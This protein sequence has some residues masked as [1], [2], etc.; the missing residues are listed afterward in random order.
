MGRK[1]P[2]LVDTIEFTDSGFVVE[3]YLDRNELDFFAEVG[4]GKVVRAPDIEKLRAL[5]R[6]TAKGVGTLSWIPVLRIDVSS[7]PFERNALDRSDADARWTERDAHTLEVTV[8]RFWVAKKPGGKWIRSDWEPEKV[9]NPNES[10]WLDRWVLPAEDDDVARFRRA[11]PLEWPRENGAF[12]LPHVKD[13]PS[14]HCRKTV[15]H[16]PHTDELWVALTGLLDR[17]AEVG[18]RVRD[19]VT[20]AE[21][22][23]RLLGASGPLALGSAAPGENFDA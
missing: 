1:K 21:G 3:L 4:E 19:L 12:K 22:R 13:E 15:A 7:P 18:A 8:T 14:Y 16:L 5:V 17:L 10:E 2:Q 9:R 6:K 20:T 23:E 11:K